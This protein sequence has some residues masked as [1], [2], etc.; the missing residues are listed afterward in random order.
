VLI[1][2]LRKSRDGVW[3][4]PRHLV[5]EVMRGWHWFLDRIRGRD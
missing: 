2:A 3:R 4:S 1:E 5:F